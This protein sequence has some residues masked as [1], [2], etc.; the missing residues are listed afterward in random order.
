MHKLTVQ[1]N[2][3]QYE[4]VRAAAEKAGKALDEVIKDLVNVN[5]DVP[6][7]ARTFTVALSCFP[8]DQISLEELSV[9]AKVLA[10]AKAF[11][12]EGRWI[13]AIA[14]VRKGHSYGL[15]EAKFIVDI[16]RAE[17]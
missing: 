10:E 3:A 16:L 15:K 13:A 8:S 2:E 1:F 11:V 6:G 5:L 9:S 12:A 7:T 4:A 17:V 14:A